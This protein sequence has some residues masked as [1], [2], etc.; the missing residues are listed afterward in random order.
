MGLA[1]VAAVGACS[2]ASGLAQLFWQ[3]TSGR[4]RRWQPT[5]QRAKAP[6]VHRGTFTSTELP[7]GHPIQGMRHWTPAWRGTSTAAMDGADLA[8]AGPA[9]APVAVRA[10]AAS[11]PASPASRWEAVAAPERPTMHRPKPATLL[12]P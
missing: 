7:S 8:T 5:A 1:S 9:I 12:P 3:L 10:A 6:P 2:L 11:R 4:W